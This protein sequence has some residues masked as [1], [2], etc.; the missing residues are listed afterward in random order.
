MATAIRKHMRD[1]LAVAGLTVIALAITY[2]LL[3]E[4]RQRLPILEEKPFELKAE[5]V[6][7][8]SDEVETGQ[9][10]ETDPPA[11]EKADKGATVTVHISKGAD[12]VA[13]PDVVGMTYSD[14]YDTL[15]AAGFVPDQSGQGNR[16]V[17]T[18]PSPGKR[19]KRG[20]GVTIYLRR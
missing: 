11:G 15:V 17:K 2:I 13:V 1:F 12:L 4:Q 19:V 3:Q 8:F 16:V 6:Q 20:S 9:V 10:I 5:F 18:D 14:A 7:D